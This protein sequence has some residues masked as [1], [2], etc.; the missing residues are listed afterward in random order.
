MYFLTLVT[1][2]RRP[3]LCSDLSRRILRQAIETVRANHPFEIRAIVLLPNHLHTLWR[4]PGEDGEFSMRVGLVKKG[5]TDAYLLAGGREG[6]STSSRDRHRVRGVWEK[7]FYEHT[8]RNYRGYKRHLDY[9]HFNPAKH[10][11]V[12]LPRE[13]PWSTFH[14]FLKKGEYHPDWCGD[15]PLQGG[16]DIEPD[17]W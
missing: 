11:L 9:I 12:R 3:I 2:E 1:H 6:A 15:V 7:R 4:L 5:F 10:G 17:Q 16:V 8:I 13:W 14:A